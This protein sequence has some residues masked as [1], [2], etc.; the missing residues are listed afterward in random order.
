[1]GYRI[2]IEKVTIN[3][4]WDKEIK[5]VYYGTKLYGYVENKELISF[6]YLVSIGKCPE[7]YYFDYNSSI[8][9]P[10]NKKEL[11]IFLTLYSMDLDNSKL[12]YYK[13]KKKGWFLETPEI[14]EELLKEL[15]DGKLPKGYY[16]TYIISWG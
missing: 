13:D 4:N 7:D 14:K 2:Q 6:M 9:I 15:P 11:T 8:E 10:L 16:D 5:N 1:M 3:E 12:G